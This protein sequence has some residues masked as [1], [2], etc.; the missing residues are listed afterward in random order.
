MDPFM[1]PLDDLMS[2]RSITVSL[3]SC[4]NGP[5]HAKTTTRAFESNSC[6]SITCSNYVNFKSPFGG[7]R[8]Y[9]GLAENAISNLSL[10]LPNLRTFFLASWDEVH[11]RS[12]KKC[13]SEFGYRWVDD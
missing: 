10:S 13:A 1:S 11:L 3:R 12:S 7:S 9:E 2:D 5:R 4:L 8:L 6:F